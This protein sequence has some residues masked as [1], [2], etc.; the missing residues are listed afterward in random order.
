MRVLVVE[1]DARLASPLTAALTAAGY[2]VDSE[3][4]GET[5]WFNGDT[6]DYG[7]VVLDLGLP[8]LDGLTILKR[9]RQA[10][11]TMP[12]LIATARS[13]WQERVEAIESGADDY[14]VKPYRLEEAVARVRAL[15]RRSAGL[16]NSR[17][18]LGPLVLDLRMMSVTR[19]GEPIELTRQEYRLLA[20]LAQR[21][22][23]V[24]SQ[25]ELTNHL[26]DRDVELESNAVEV[27]VARVRKRL[28]AD[29]IKTRRGLGY[30]V[31]GDGA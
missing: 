2:R 27:V 9:W 8:S 22:G 20:Y 4:D 17:V 14:I 28:G 1:D 25:R 30:F 10:G 3:T 18:A 24:V 21:R 5:A 12:V 29:V 7:A 13:D 19:D 31:V 23:Q 11:R 6:Y 15:I 26:Y 16:A